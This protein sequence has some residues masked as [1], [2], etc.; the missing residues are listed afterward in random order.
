[1]LARWTVLLALAGC[2]HDRWIIVA[3]RG[4]DG[5]PIADATVAAVCGPT[6]DRAD[7]SAKLTTPDG[8]VA[9]VFDSE[10]AHPCL[11]SAT[12]DGYRTRHQRV[13]KLCEDERSRCAPLEVRLEPE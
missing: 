10:P 8:T 11:V 7:S 1:M 5:M 9:L 3:V 6:G 12:A 2:G 13:E 4:P